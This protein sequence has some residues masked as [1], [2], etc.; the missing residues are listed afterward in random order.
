MPDV[1]VMD[2]DIVM[3]YSELAWQTDILPALSNF[4]TIPNLS[5]DFD[6]DWEHNTHMWAAANILY[7]WGWKQQH[8]FSTDFHTEIIKEAGRTPLLYTEVQGTPG[9]AGGTILIYGHMD[10]QP[11][12]EGWRANLGPCTPV[13]EGD[14]LFGRGPADDGYAYFAALCALRIVAKLGL[15]YSRC[16]IMI[17]AGEESGSPDLSYYMDRLA[18][19]IG[20]VDLI[21]ALDSGCIDYNRLCL[22][23]SLRG[24]LAADLHTQ[25]LTE[26]KH[27]GEGGGIVPDVD[28][29]ERALLNTIEDAE[30]GKILLPELEITI[31]EER[32]DD[33]LVVADILGS[34]E[35]INRFSW[36]PGCHPSNLSPY[37]LILDNTWRISMHKSGSSIPSLDK[38]ANVLRPEQT[39]RLVFRL[40]PTLDP[41]YA[42]TCLRNRLE[43]RTPQGAQVS[44]EHKMSARGWNAPTLTPWLKDSL[45]SASIAFFG[46]PMVAMGEGGCIPFMTMLGERFPN[47][48]FVIT[49]VLGPKSNAH[50]PNEALHLPTAMRVTAC[51][52]KIIANHARHV[53]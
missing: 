47:A 3:K 20:S 7:E 27:S 18:D 50:A 52:A 4:V 40:P 45:D 19:E 16:I 30:T 5:P 13:L 33:A 10:K 2:T 26:G 28:R 32:L 8:Y 29:I 15:P 21:I 35:I 51:V 34:K 49:G 37:E 46:N 31:P 1:T 53:A 39:S 6:D 42:Y 41:D 14:Y 25:I 44:F 48:Q 38:A 23:T 11:A 43:N 17:E 9:S 12:G 36:I 24:Y 22:T